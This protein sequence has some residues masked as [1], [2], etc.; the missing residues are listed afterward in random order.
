[1]IGEYVKATPAGRRRGAGSSLELLQICLNGYAYQSLG[2]ADAR[3]FDR[4]FNAKGSEHREYCGIFGPEKI[5]P[6]LGQF[7]GWFLVR[8]VMARPE[9]LEAVAR[10]TRLFAEWLGEK[11]HIRS[12]R[13]DS[14]PV[15]RAGGGAIDTESPAPIFRERTK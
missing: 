12:G 4:L 2:P 1:M 9:D 14:R 15:H 7:L 5:V 10:D 11:G 6:E 13:F 8:K 3:L